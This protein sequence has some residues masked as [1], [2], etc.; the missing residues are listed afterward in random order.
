MP[1]GFVCAKDHEARASTPMTVICFFILLPLIPPT[2]KVV[3]LR[4]KLCHRKQRCGNMPSYEILNSGLLQTTSSPF[5]LVDGVVNPFLFDPMPESTILRHQLEMQLL[6]VLHRQV[7]L[8]G[9]FA[10]STGFLGGEFDSLHHVHTD[11]LPS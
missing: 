1:A 4:R 2:I 5:E 6:P 8:G 9:M 11:I 10:L 3:Y 7:D